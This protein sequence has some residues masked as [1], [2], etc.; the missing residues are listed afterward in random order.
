MTVEFLMNGPVY[1]KIALRYQNE[2]AKIGIV[3]EIR[4]VDTLAV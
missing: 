2:L 3:C 4:S 1:E